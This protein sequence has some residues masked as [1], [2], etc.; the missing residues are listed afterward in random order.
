M[1][2]IGEARRKSRMVGALT[3]SV[4][5]EVMRHLNVLPID[6]LAHLEQLSDHLPKV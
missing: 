5:I 1:K 2:F 3:Q 4:K 6:N